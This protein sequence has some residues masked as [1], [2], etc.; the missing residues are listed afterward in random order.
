MVNYD[1]NAI[2]GSAWAARAAA[3]DINSLG[4][5]VSRQN[6]DWTDLL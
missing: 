2:S 6:S 4:D 1:I 3:D 5:H